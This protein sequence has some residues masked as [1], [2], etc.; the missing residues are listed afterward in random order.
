MDYFSLLGK[1]CEILNFPA[2]LSLMTLLGK[3]KFWDEY[4]GFSVR[5]AELFGRER[6]KIKFSQLLPGSEK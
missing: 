6:K 5:M 2:H 4:T 3:K 1:S